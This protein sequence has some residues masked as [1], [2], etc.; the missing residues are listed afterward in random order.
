MAWEIDVNEFDD[1]SLSPG[2]ERLM[3]EHSHLEEHVESFNE[4]TGTYPE[5]IDE[6]KNEHTIVE[7]PNYLYQVDRLVFVHVYGALDQPVT[8]YAVEP[9][10]PPDENEV[11][12]RFKLEILNRN[13]G[14][15]IR[16][17]EDIDA[18]IERS[19]V[20]EDDAGQD[21]NSRLAAIANRVSNLT[22]IGKLRVDPRR[23]RRLRYQFKRDVLG[24]GPLKPVLAD[25]HNE[26]IH[27][28]GRDAVFVDH[29]VFGMLPTN[30]SFGGKE[31]FD[32]FIH[33]MTERI[34]NPVSDADPIVD[35]TLPDGS[36]LNVI[37]SDD[38]SIQGPTLTIRQQDEVPLTITA[39]TRGGTFSP[40]AAAYCWLAL[41]NEASIFVVGETASGKTTTLN[42]LTTFIPRDSKIYTAEDTA[43][44]VPPHETWQQ[45]LTRESPGEDTNDVDLFDLVVAALRS[46]P[47]Y[48]IVGEVRGEEGRMAFQ[49]IQSGHP[50]MLTFH[51]SDI[52]SMIQRFTGNPINVP[53]TYLDN[54]DAVIFQ[55]FIKG[56]DYR[57]VTSIH[58]IEEYS[59]HAGGVVTKE[60]FEWESASD[61]LVFKGQNNST[62]LEGH[63]AQ[64][65]GYED[66]KRVYDDLEFRRRII[67]QMVY[68][69]IVGYNEV[70]EVMASFQQDGVAG[71]PFDVQRPRG[72][73]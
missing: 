34:G 20:V 52:K 62:V 70:N 42:A 59:K 1:R 13:L 41:E 8:Y 48:I 64:L 66:P 56:D 39:I 5:V 32:Q 35:G 68:K 36:R 51:A 29:D 27:V 58:E 45:L 14:G 10:L 25:D 44:V 50:V 15:N 55:N 6:P 16:D 43:E 47:D 37:Y 21:R 22:A 28:L 33:S 31:A 49:A 73:F 61:D 40:T 3:A 23:Y 63:V 67:E 4:D 11:Y 71:L 26:D 69:D 60:V 53:E 18:V 9:T 46:R 65:R 24:L 30:L 17:E 57:R 19:V 54:L 7:H 72:A 2:L 12:Q 38:I